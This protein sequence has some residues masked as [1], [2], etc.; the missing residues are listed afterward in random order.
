MA[1]TDGSGAPSSGADAELLLSCARCLQRL[2]RL[3]EGQRAVQAS[4]CSPLESW[5]A[6]TKPV[7]SHRRHKRQCMSNL[8]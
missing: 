8:E 2:C 5:L 6:Q 3:P 7:L 4:A 1:R